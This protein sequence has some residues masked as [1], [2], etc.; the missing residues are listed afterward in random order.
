MSGIK[1]SLHGLPRPKKE[2]SLLVLSILLISIS[3]SPKTACLVNIIHLEIRFF[4][5]KMF[6]HTNEYTAITG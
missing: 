6:I 4:S 5:L 1:P 3:K 2:K